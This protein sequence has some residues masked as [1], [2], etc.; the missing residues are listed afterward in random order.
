[1]SSHCDQGGNVVIGSM[2]VPCLHCDQ[3]DNVVTD[4]MAVPCVCIMFRDTML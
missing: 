2:V 1:M 3:G 4:I